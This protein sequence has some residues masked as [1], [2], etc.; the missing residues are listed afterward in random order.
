MKSYIP[1]SC[2]NPLLCLPYLGGQ[3]TNH[4]KTRQAVTDICLH[5]NY[6]AVNAAQ[7]STVYFAEQK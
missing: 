1:H 3:G 4:I 2:A 7:S 5:L 6:V